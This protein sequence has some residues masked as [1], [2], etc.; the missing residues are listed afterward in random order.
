MLEKSTFC[1]FFL[2]GKQVSKRKIAKFGVNNITFSTKNSEPF[3]SLFMLTKFIFLI[4]CTINVNLAAQ[5]SA[6]KQ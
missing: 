1:Y 4:K 3:K 5:K 6:R 2:F